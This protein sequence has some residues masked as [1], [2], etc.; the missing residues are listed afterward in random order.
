MSEQPKSSLALVKAMKEKRER[1][2]AEKARKCLEERSRKA[3]ERHALWLPVLKELA[4]VEEGYPGQLTVRG[5]ASIEECPG[6]FMPR[7]GCSYSLDT[8]VNSAPHAVY[9]LKVDGSGGSVL[10]AAASTEE[11][12]PKILE[13]IAGNL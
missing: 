6:F 12:L 2:A 9:R 10:L 7:Y 3:E 13:L 4:A 1:D 11:L 8:A 5:L